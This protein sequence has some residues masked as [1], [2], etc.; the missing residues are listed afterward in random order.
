[1]SLLPRGS[2][3]L[4]ANTV[5]TSAIGFVFWTLAAHRYAASTVGVFSSVTSGASLLAAIAA[6]GLPL[7]MTRHIASAEHPRELILVADRD[8]FHGWHHAVPCHCSLSW[9]AA[10]LRAA[11]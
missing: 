9:A 1:M 2:L 6:L 4:L 7:T 3:Y 10:S 5:T 11:H 8:N